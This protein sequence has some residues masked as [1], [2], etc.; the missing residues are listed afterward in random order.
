MAGAQDVF[1]LGKMLFKGKS[2]PAS[3][4]P[5]T[6]SDLDGFAGLVLLRKLSS[7]VSKQPDMNG[8]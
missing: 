5:A 8:R 3:S 1:R 2:F 7:W 4:P 6:E